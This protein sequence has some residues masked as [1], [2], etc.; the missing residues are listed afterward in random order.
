[1]SAEVVQIVR[2]AAP[3]PRAVELDRAVEEVARAVGCLD[4]YQRIAVTR[5]IDEF[6]DRVAWHRCN[7]WD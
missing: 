3:D 1:M 4:V 6:G 5:A 2:V 7:P